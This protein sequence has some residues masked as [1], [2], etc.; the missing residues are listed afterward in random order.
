MGTAN[1]NG[2]TNAPTQFTAQYT[3]AMMQ[4]FQ[5]ELGY[6]TGNNAIASSTNAAGDNMLS[7]GMNATNA[8]LY[9][10]AGFT[11]QGGTDYNI[12]AAGQYADNPYTSGQ[13]AAS[14][15]DANQEFNDVQNPA[16]VRFAAG[17]G[18]MNSTAP[19]VQQGIVERG[20]AQKAADI[21]A[22]LR[23][24]AY[25]T[26]LQTAQN[27]ANSLNSSNL[28]ALMAAANGG[29][30][31][32][33]SGVNANTNAVGQQTG[34]FNIANAGASNINAGNQAPLTN[35]MQAWNFGE[36]S[37]FTALD[38][39]YNIIGNKSWGSNTTGTSTTTSTPS[40]LSQ[41]GQGMGMVGSL[42]SM[43]NPLSSFGSNSGWYPSNA[44]YN[45]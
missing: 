24:N 37:P 18:N 40:T 22:T 8:G 45:N 41:I 35:Q 25:N 27:T 19:A 3:P 29:T 28:S 30:G 43:G 5:Q 4:A 36:N 34:L 39:Y 20:L 17:S 9:G 26:G 10:L 21:S 31:A 23:G 15:R 6:G 11:P 2:A 42:L 38:N 44:W 13:V 1:A 12:N 14:M 7:S 16:M 32:V 33:N